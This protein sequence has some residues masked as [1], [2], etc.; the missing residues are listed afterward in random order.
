MVAYSFKKRF[1]DPIVAL[2]KRQTIRAD[3]KRHARPGEPVQLYTGMRTR[4]CLKIL[5]QDPICRAV[6][7]ILI[8][9]VGG[10]VDVL[11]DFAPQIFRGAALDEFARL[12]GFRDWADMNSFWAGD[13]WFAG[14]LIEWEP[15]P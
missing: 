7:P 8:D 5:A 12:D 13:L 3:R 14:V 11:R 9:L 1:A 4:H 10:K 2:T 15:A 6:S